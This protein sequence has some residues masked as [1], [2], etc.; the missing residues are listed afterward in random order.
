VGE[1]DMVARL[2]GLVPVRLLQ[3]LVRGLLPRVLPTLPAAAPGWGW[4]LRQATPAPRRDA[5]AA[6]RHLPGRRQAGCGGSG[7]GSEAGPRSHG[8]H[9]PGRGGPSRLE[10]GGGGG[11]YQPSS[12]PTGQTGRSCN[13]DKW[14]PGGCGDD[15]TAGD[16]KAAV[17]QPR[18]R[19]RAGFPSGGGELA[20]RRQPLAG[21][22]LLVEPGER[23]T[24]RTDHHGGRDQ[25][26][27]DRGGDSLPPQ[28]L[29]EPFRE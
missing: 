12:F 19:D 25:P 20:E 8:H 24:P 4:R 9:P 7:S 26:P 18:L 5:A 16:Q 3:L 21:P 13:A 1:L 28:R 22:R 27:L 14:R 29:A 17:G 11:L 23:P 15:R 2:R 6:H 10:S